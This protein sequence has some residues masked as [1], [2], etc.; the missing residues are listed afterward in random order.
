MPV[1]PDTRLVHSHSASDVMSHTRR[2]PAL[3]KT[4]QRPSTLATVCAFVLAA[5]ILS[6][7]R[8][9]LLLYMNLRNGNAD[10]CEAF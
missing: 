1:F 8:R 6:S 2:R 5:W 10:E 7:V 9:S 4:Q 3:H